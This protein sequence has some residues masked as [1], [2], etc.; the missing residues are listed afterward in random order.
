[1]PLR[2]ACDATSVATRF[3]FIQENAVNPFNARARKVLPYGLVLGAALL[4]SGCASDDPVRQANLQ[5]LKNLEACG[6]F[7]RGYDPYYPSDIQE[8]EA[9]LQRGECGAK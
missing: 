8:A 3:I 6:Y 9:R 7:P 4:L 1:M 5:D 2:C